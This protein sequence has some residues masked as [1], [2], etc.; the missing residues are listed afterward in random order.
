MVRPQAGFP[1]GDGFLVRRQRL[2][3]DPSIRFE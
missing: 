3:S 2:R 1:G